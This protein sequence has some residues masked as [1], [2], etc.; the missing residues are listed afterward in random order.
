MA[1]KLIS[2]QRIQCL[3]EREA[4]RRDARYLLYWMQ[5]SQRSTCNHALEYAIQRANAVG[6][7]VVV[8]FGL[9]DGYPEANL[10]HYRF[11]VEGLADVQRALRRRDILMVVQHGEPDEIALRLGRDAALIVCDRGYLRHQ[12]RWRDR[13]ADEAACPVVQVETDAIVPVETAS[14]KREYAARTIRRKLQRHYP[15]FRVELR[16]TPVDRG[17]LDLDLESMVIDDAAAACATLDLDTSVKPV[18]RFRGGQS[19]AEQ[20]FTRFID[21]SLDVYDAH[22]NRPETDDVS[23]MSM[24]LHFGQVSPLWLALQLEAATDKPADDRDAYIEELLVR[25]ELSLNYCH[26]EPRYDRYEALPDWARRTLAEH[27]DDERPHVYTAAQLAEAAT[28]D[29][30][31][32]AAMREMRDTGYMHNY[33]RMYWGKKI[34]EWSETPEQAFETALTLNNKYFLDGRDPNSYANVAW[35]FGLHDRPWQERPIFGKTRYMAASGL[36]RKCDIAGYVRKV[37]E[38]VDGEATERRSDGAT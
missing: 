26:Y 4:P 7:P 18:D 24:Y 25:R 8:G 22:R 32:N 11:M 31:W 10:R 36:E 19:V 27:R 23:Y 20:I 29:D 17:S 37:E 5:A 6:L 15:T 28:H 14:D 13:V 2:E 35:V 3:T 38:R 12:R 30:Y 9:M 1:S 33:M 16:T 34:L 21:R